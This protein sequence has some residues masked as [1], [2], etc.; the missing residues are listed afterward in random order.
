MTTTTT[1][2]ASPEGVAEYTAYLTSRSQVGR[3]ASAL[4]VC[5]AAIHH[6]AA[7]THDCPDGYCAACFYLTS[8]LSVLAA[9]DHLDER[10]V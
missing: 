2:Q 7:T 10:E 5:Q 3:Y 6:L 9:V 4:G 8:A 1:V